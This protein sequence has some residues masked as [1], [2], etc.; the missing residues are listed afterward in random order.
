[1]VSILLPLLLFPLAI[2][3]LAL[4]LLIGWPVALHVWVLPW[5]ISRVGYPLLV[6]L[7]RGLRVLLRGLWL[8]RLLVG[9]HVC[10]ALVRIPGNTMMW[11]IRAGQLVRWWAGFGGEGSTLLLLVRHVKFAWGGVLRPRL[12][13]PSWGGVAGGLPWLLGRSLRHTIGAL[14]VWGFWRTILRVWQA[15]F[16]GDS[17]ADGAS[18]LAVRTF[19]VGWL[20]WA[21]AVHAR[22]LR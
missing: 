16:G 21:R 5:T 19:R 10:R 8:L 18:L 17:G 1:M 6:W 4:L 3:V 7:V 13:G 15:R 12:T 14:W 2:L 22:L 20:W 11:S 9:S